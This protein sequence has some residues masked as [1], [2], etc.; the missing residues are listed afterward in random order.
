MQVSRLG[1][2]LV[3]EALI[4]LQEKDKFNRSE[5]ADDDSVDLTVNVRESS[6]GT[7]SAATGG[8]VGT[9][10][11]VFVAAQPAIITSDIT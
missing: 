8:F 9:G 4:G 2:P 10:A 3:N 7:F 11:F 6:T 1:W 5:P